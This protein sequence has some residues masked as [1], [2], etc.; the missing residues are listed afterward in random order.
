MADML[1]KLYELPELEPVL[2]ALKNNGIT[3]R[4]ARAYEK[5]VVINWIHTHFNPEWASE[6]EAAFSRS[7]VSCYIAIK[8]GKLLGFACYEVTCKNFFGPTGVSE[9]N[10][11]K[12]IGKG[13]LLASLH[14][15]RAMDY[16]YAI[17][18]G[19][20]PAKF[21]EKTAGAI[22]IQDSTPG[23]YSDRLAK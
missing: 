22:L 17:I 1:V 3:I 11:G 9:E 6:C 21:Y 19:I 13:L 23:I 7:P 15:L 18:G 16:A 8:H 12:G 4:N 2:G 5:H 10:H 20:G 14:A